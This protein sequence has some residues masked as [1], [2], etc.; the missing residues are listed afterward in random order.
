VTVSAR[1]NEDGNEPLRGRRNLAQRLTEQPLNPAT[2]AGY[3]GPTLGTSV[4]VA[5][6]M[7]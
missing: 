2:K 4:Q 7:Q 3:R 5:W 6:W 1:A